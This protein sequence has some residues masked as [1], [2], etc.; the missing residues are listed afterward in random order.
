MWKKLSLKS[1]IKEHWLKGLVF[2]LSLLVVYLAT[3]AKLDSNAKSRIDSS[4]K[5][6]LGVFAT[7][8]AL[9][10]V[11]S[12]AQGTEVGVGLTFSIGEILDP[13]NDLVERFS[14]IMLASLTSLG[15]QKILMNIV[16]FQG[17]EILLIGSLALSNVLLF[18]K[19]KKYKQ[20]KNL[21][22]KFTILLIFLRFSI[23]FMAMSNEYVYINFVKQEYNI[24]QSQRV[25]NSAKNDISKFD[26]KKASYFSTD[27][28]KN[29]MHEFE[30]VASD[31]ADHIVDLII[32]FIFQTM[33]F[34]IL[35][36]WFL[37]KIIISFSRSFHNP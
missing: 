10:G 13:I 11:I 18:F 24:E 30:I 28:Y 36:L 2:L 33:L 35:F 27:Y 15:I 1:K 9:N 21:F 12:L 26:D 23:P 4:F 14:W 37:Y 6:A 31:A 20:S 34:P 22:F 29:K 5:Q 25:I 16:V 8:K 19:F 3:F 17:F 32:V 7:A